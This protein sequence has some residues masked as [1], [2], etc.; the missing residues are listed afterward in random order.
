MRVMHKFAAML[1]AVGVVLALAS[2]AGSYGE[3]KT[4]IAVIVKATDSDFWLKVQDGVSAASIEYN[5]AVTFEGAQNEQDYVAQNKLIQQAIDDGVDAIVLSAISYADS[6][7]LIEKAAKNG[8]KIVAIDSNVDSEQ[9]ALFIGT[10]NQ[11][12][13]KK[14][15][16][17]AIGTLG[18]DRD[19]RI[20][21]V[22]LYESTE[23]GR[24]REKGFRD[25]VASVPNAEIVASIHVGSDAESATQGALSLLKAHPE[26]NVLVGLNEWMTLGVGKAIEQLELSHKV[27]GVG[28][29][30]NA[31]CI[32]MLEH[33]HLDVL[34]AQNPFAIGYLGV[35]AAH[36]LIADSLAYGDISELFTDVTVVT[37][38][39]LNDRNVQKILFRFR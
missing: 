33:E 3:D 28:F 9:V 17:A 29:D 18:M 1:L 23:N 38:E 30:T 6:S 37:R 27:R 39:N 14:A 10:D 21:L 16:E 13:G 24:Q 4:Q 15:A 35:Q 20:G 22:G 7:K 26:I 19:I 32:E 11:N 36:E 8:I 25:A 5:I 12:A 2:C 31:Q 34:I